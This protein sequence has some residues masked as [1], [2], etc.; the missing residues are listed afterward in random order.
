MSNEDR[1][2]IDH[3]I[4]GQIAGALI[5]AFVGFML[6]ALLGPIISAILNQ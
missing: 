5:F 2:P 4:S 1:P 3:G 6:W